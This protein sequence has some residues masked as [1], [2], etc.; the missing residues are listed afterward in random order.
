MD[1]SALIIRTAFS[2]DWPQVQESTREGLLARVYVGR[3][4]IDKMKKG[5][6][7]AAKAPSALKATVQAVCEGNHLREKRCD[8][9]RTSYCQ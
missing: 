4:G 6:R 5:S 8:H 7:L 2:K 9:A 1:H 3:V